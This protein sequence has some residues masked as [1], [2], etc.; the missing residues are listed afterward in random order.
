M[1][2]LPPVPGALKASFQHTIGGVPAFV[3]WYFGY[4]G[5]APLSVDAAAL[6]NNMKSAWSTNFAPLAHPQV[7][8]TQ[9]QVTD[10]SSV[11]GG[12]GTSS[13]AVV[14]TRTGGPLVAASSCML[15]LKIG[16]RYRGGKPRQYWP[17]GTATDV[18]D[19]QHWTS[20]FTGGVAPAW[21]AMQTAI[22]ASTWT[23]GNIVRS[24]NISY[25]QG[26]TVVTNPVTGR[27]RNAGKL[28]TTPVVD[29]VGS[30]VVSSRI[31]TQRRR[32]HFSA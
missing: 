12:Q 5:S 30:S 20:A 32:E 8:L 6:A 4:S 15:L 10:L 7:T 27:A 11:T 3:H 9:V 18:L 16:R 17:L 31:A 13:G 23:G 19:P 26:F 2:A 29:T 24:I 25:F 22:L 14:G 1:P 21:N 28:R